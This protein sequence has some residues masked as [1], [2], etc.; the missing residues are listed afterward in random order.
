MTDAPDPLAQS[1]YQVRFDWGRPG[2]AR[3]AGEADVLVLVDVF[4][5]TTD[6]VLAVEAGASAP[7]GELAELAG[8][9]DRLV[10]AAAL[11]NR[12]AVARFILGEQERQGRRLA[13]AIIAARA[14]DADGHPR[15]AVEDQLGAGAV[16]E[17]LVALGIDHTSPEAAVACA[18]FE[19][20]RNATT[21]LTGAS[22]GGLELAAAG[23]RD[24]VRRAVRIDESEAVP[25][26]DGAGFRAA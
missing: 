12:S 26:L 18:A 7:A 15:F 17:A 22:A 6:A 8:S 25:R 5:A 14:T 19:G 3:L 16:V 13:V 21:H 1:R 2:A 9:G 20:L 23:R 11:R 24:E 4:T 10:L